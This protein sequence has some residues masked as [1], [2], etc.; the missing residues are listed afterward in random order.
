MPISESWTFSL[1]MVSVV[2]SVSMDTGRSGGTAG[3]GDMREGGV[4]IEVAT[5]QKKFLCAE[6]E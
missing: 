6:S 5:T 4:C 1:A 3:E 2:D